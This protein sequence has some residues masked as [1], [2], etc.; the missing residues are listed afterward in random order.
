[1]RKKLVVPPF[2]AEG[3]KVA[4]VSPSFHTPME[5]VEGAADVLRGWGFEPVIGRNVDKEYRGSY[6]G[7]AQER[8]HDLMAALEDPEVKAIICNRGGYGTI[9]LI[10]LVPE[11]ALRENPK[12]LVGFSDITTLLGMETRAGV[13]SIHGT[14]GKFLKESCGTDISSTLLRDIL[15]GTVPDY[16]IPSHKYNCEGTASGTLVG[17]NLAT[18]TPLLGTSADITACNDIIL[19][20]EEVEENMT[21]ID[22]LFNTLRFNGVL[23]RCKGVI[24][25]EFTDCDANLGYESVEELLYSYIKDCNIPLCCG[26]PAGHGDVNLPLIMGAKVTLEVNAKQSHLSFHVNGI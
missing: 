22:R 2:L 7:T 21:H 17:G 19:F 8:A 25:G 24:L 16:V 1:M 20:V 14:M 23:D 6:A 18:F 5:N 15:T 26:F 12:W 4:L 9:G 3:D 10:D 13:M 11:A